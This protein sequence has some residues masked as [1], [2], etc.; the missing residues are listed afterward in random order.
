MIGDKTRR[1]WLITFRNITNAGNE[2]TVIFTIIPREASGTLA[3][4]VFIDSVDPKFAACL[5]ANFNSMILDFVSRQKV[6]GTHLNHFILRQLPI[7]PPATYQQNLL[8]LIVPKVLE[9]IY[10]ANDLKPFA[11]DC[12]Y[13]GE[14]FVWEESRRRQLKS[15]LDAIYFI[16]YGISREDAD[17]IL[18][19]FPILKRREKEAY[20]DYRYKNSVLE[21]YDQYFEK[22]NAKL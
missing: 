18:D 8:E 13:D 19:T 11:N 6:G 3:P 22:I 17:Y 20:V 16:L 12:G 14:P 7:L 1:K 9:L 15:E 5:I 4:Q 2:R 10:V 21:Y